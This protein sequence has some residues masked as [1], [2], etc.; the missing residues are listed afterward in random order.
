V[1]A[2]LIKIRGPIKFDPGSATATSLVGGERGRP[3]ATARAALLRLVV[4]W[5][6]PRLRTVAKVAIRALWTAVAVVRPKARRPQGVRRARL[7]G[8]WL[9]GRQ[10]AGHDGGFEPVAGSCAGPTHGTAY[11]SRGHTAN[12]VSGP[13]FR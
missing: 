2:G 4:G 8:V 13:R 6:Q 7:L 9:A 5:R 10:G 12:E 11:P 1:L 3:S